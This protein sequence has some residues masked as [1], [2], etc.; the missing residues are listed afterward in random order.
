MPPRR[1][2]VTDQ[3]LSFK[4]TANLASTQ[5]LHQPRCPTMRERPGMPSTYRPRSRL[6]TS[7][8]ISV[9]PP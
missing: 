4:T 1:L 9:V 5:S 6:T 3:L 7:F 8:T 2:T